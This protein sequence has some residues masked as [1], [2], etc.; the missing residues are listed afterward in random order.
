MSKTV[1]EDVIEDGHTATSYLF[2][3][4]VK[5][6][7]M[8]ENLSMP[9]EDGELLVSGNGSLRHSQLMVL[10]E[11][12][13]KDM[14][15][16]ES[17]LTKAIPSLIEQTT[18]LDLKNAL[19]GHLTE[20]EEQCQRL[21]KI[22]T[23]LGKDATAIRCEAMEGLIKE[24]EAIVAK[25]ETGAMRDAGIISAVQKVEHYEI[26]SYGTLR[27]FAESLGL[28]EAVELLAASLSEEKSADEQLTVIA[29]NSVNVHASE[30]EAEHIAL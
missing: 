15:W 7:I 19:S 28:D 17:A 2:C 14:Y 11:D 24:T 18:S 6:R 30:Q 9:I 22:F 27:Q 10:F 8:D 12:Q 29:T 4:S 13:L 25:C 23:L 20:T 3:Q 5:A 26:A 1:R 16:A 21:A